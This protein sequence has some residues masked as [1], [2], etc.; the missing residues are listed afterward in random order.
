VTDAAGASVG[1]LSDHNPTSLGPGPEGL[2]EY[3]EAA[4]ALAEGV[5][6]LIHDAQYT[7]A[8]LPARIHFAHAAVDYAVGLARS[9]RVAQLQLFHHDP[10]RTDDQLDAIVAGLSQAGVPVAAAAEGSVVEVRR[11]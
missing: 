1:Y 3:H 2:G 10:P 5:D 4:R 7:A 9:C 11:A 6:L 8:E